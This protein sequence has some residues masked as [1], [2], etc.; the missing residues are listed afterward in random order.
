M[1]FKLVRKEGMPWTAHDIDEVV[2][3]GAEVK[4][5]D[6]AE[7]LKTVKSWELIEFCRAVLQ[8]EYRHVITSNDTDI[9]DVA[10]RL[11]EA[12]YS[13]ELDSD[14]EG[15]RDDILTGAIENQDDLQEQLHSACV[16]TVMYPRHAYEVLLHTDHF[17][18]GFEEGL[19]NFDRKNPDNIA[20][21]IAHWA[22]Y[23]DLQERLSKL[24]DIDIYDE[25]LGRC[26]DCEAKGY[27]VD[28]SDIVHRCDSCD[29]YDTREEAIKAAVHDKV[30]KECLRC[31]NKSYTLTGVNNSPE[32]CPVC[33]N[34]DP[35]EAQELAK[36]E[37][38]L[39]PPEEEET[40]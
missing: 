28:S 40:E 38:G 27:T 13:A 21:A 3:E 8:R 12:A 29:K 14:A 36:D 18:Y 16:S 26:Q 35:E 11:G 23:A 7:L 20:T 5:V 33:S 24:D 1:K 30:V 17:E 10:F 4:E 34:L 32:G 22:Y 25:H 39:E 31:D 2:D 9:S 37:D 15:L 19:I 6:A